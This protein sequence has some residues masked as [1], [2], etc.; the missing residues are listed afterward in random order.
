MKK[1]KFIQA[2]FCGITAM[3]LLILLKD[4]INGKQMNEIKEKS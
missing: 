1:Y 2:L 3:F 4:V